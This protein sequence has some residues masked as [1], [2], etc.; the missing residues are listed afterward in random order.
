MFV[1]NYKHFCDT[2]LFLWEIH[3]FVRGNIYLLEQRKG[4][5]RD[6]FPFTISELIYVLQILVKKLKLCKKS[7]FII[8]L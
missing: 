2:H 5:V 3:L 7:H 6:Q 1:V 8:I 4:A